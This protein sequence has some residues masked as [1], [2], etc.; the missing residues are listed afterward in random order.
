MDD[1]LDIMI[2]DDN[3][4]SRDYVTKV[5]LDIP[6]VR[7]ANSVSGGNAALSRLR[8][9]PVDMVFLDIEMP[10]M[11]GIETLARIRKDFPEV[12]VVMMSAAHAS[13]ADKVVKALE[14]G[15]VDFIPKMSDT[16]S[17]FSEFRLRLLT[18]TGMIRSRKN[19]RMA[20]ILAGLPLKAAKA[21]KNDPVPIKETTR[22]KMKKS[23]YVPVIDVVA[24][25]VSTGGPNAL[26]EVIP[27]LPAELGVPVLIVQ[28]MPPFLTASL[29]RSLNKKSALEVKEASDGERVLPGTVYIASGGKHMTVHP[30]KII[31]F[32]TGPP[33]NSVRPSADVLFNSL[34]GAY[35]SKILSVVMTGMGCD[36]TE[37]VRT[38][39]NKGCY[40]LSQ[41]AETCIVYGMPRSVDEELLS[42]E[43]VPLKNI[44]GRITSI[45][46]K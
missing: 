45:V 42:D 40:C 21:K 37:G 7:V 25:A 22:V 14:S 38:M 15:A 46:G 1:N 18:I 33:V 19:I 30:Q 12:D 26:A 32:N 5:M 9:S 44:A 20:K 31:R 3:E 24:F 36:G 6:G 41:T 8:R 23:L 39:K 35:G 16:G 10:G 17:A 11:D 34:P 2:V 4:C 28:H 13:D 43:R 27:L 29:A